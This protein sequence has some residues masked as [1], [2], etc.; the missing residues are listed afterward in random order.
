MQSYFALIFSLCF[1]FHVDSNIDVRYISMPVWISTKVEP[2][3]AK[4]ESSTWGHFYDSTVYM[5]NAS[6]IV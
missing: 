4:F 2:E 1:T 3:K 5:L 6:K